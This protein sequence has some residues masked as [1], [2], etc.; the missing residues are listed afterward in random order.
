MSW[1]KYLVGSN[2]VVN[3]GLDIIDQMVTDKDK[4]AELK[5]AFY[6]QELQTP[7]IPII[8]AIHKMGR[9][10]LAFAQMGFYYYTIQQY[11]TEA[12]TPELVAGVSGA[13]SIYTLVKGKGK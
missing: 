13:A 8:D 2:N 11:G 10:T 6:L 4:A 1:W 5:A 9:Q 7:T 12:I 3:K